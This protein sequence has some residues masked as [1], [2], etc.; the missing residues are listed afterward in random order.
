MM[1]GG[2]ARDIEYPPMLTQIYEVSTSEEAAAISGIGV[3]HV[4]IL[5]GPGEFPREQPL[6][7]ATRIAAAVFPPSKVSALFL[8]ADITLI[9]AWA[10][11]LCPAI[12]HLGAGPERLSP[13][14]TAKLKWALPGIAVMRSIPVVDE[15]S[16]EL[17]R[18]YEG[19]ADYLLLDSHRPQDRQ[20]GALGITHDW[21]ISRRIVARS[22]MPVL[23]AGGLG[24]DNVAEAIAAVQPAGVD[25]KTKTDRDGL[26]SKDLDR[27]R[28]F[29][30][31][32]CAAA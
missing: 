8:I 15:D 32:A 26:H 10:R 11:S 27:V 3:H 31:A 28:R 29:H 20:I 16:L 25:S 22:S 24:P 18:T 21:G 4:G 5:V 6:C 30:A 23:L 2:T 12:L 17:A 14:D 19:I 13:A 7:A 1:R 9:E